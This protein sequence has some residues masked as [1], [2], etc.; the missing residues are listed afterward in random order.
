[1]VCNAEFKLAQIQMQIQ[2]HGHSDA[3]MLEEKLAIVLN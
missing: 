2:D 3:L 1:M